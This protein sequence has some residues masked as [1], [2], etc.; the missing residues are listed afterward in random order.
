MPAVG[1]ESLGHVLEERDVG[2]ALDGN[3]V[4][5]V[6]HNELAKTHGTGHGCSLRC[7]ALLEVSV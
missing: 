3:I 6:E 5:I 1:L 4:V 7:D 2:T